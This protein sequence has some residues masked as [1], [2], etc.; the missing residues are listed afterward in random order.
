MMN[1]HFDESVGEQY[2]SKSQKIRVMSE[3]WISRNMF[4]PCCGNPHINHL[5]NNQPVADMQCD[6]CGEIFE[7][8]SKKGKLGKKINDGTYKTMIDRITSYVFIR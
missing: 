3:D 1:L 6:N 5:K 8:K 2:K 4:C 7:L